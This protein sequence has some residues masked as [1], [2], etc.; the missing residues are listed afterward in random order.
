MELALHLWEGVFKL[1]VPEVFQKDIKSLSL[2]AQTYWDKLKISITFHEKLNVVSECCNMFFFITS[3]VKFTDKHVFLYICLFEFWEELSKVSENCTALSRK[4]IV[5]I[6]D[7]PNLGSERIFVATD[8]V[9]R[10]V[11]IFLFNCNNVVF[12]CLSHKNMQSNEIN[13]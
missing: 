9:L 13:L 3:M 1:S 4:E 6:M 11:F 2:R 8:Y 10:K 7:Y 12:S 5:Q